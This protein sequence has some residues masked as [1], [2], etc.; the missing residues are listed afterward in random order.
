MAIDLAVATISDLVAERDSVCAA[1]GLSVCARS[2]EI[3]EVASRLVADCESHE[4]A[5]GM[6]IDVAMGMEVE[7]RMARE[8][9]CSMTATAQRQRDLLDEVF[10]A[11]GVDRT[12]DDAASE[13]VAMAHSLAGLRPTCGET[14]A[15]FHAEAFPCL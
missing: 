5:V 6:L 12:D 14:M 13:L 7:L 8:A 15:V 3:A 9:L 2:G 4:R 1:L 11:L 10:A